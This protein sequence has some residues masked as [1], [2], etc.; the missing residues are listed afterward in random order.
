[1][2]AAPV[3]GFLENLTRNLSTQLPT[4]IP[5][6]SRPALSRL[7]SSPTSSQTFPHQQCHWF[8]PGPHHRSRHADPESL[9]ASSQRPLPLVM[10][11]DT[12]CSY[13]DIV[14]LDTFEDDNRVTTEVERRLRQ[15]LK[16]HYRPRY[17][18]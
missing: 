11:T 17:S 3:N 1:M 10:I 2:S 4:L 14:E 15:Q 9:I 13:T 12:N 18:T 16:T 5:D 7:T 6:R 8:T